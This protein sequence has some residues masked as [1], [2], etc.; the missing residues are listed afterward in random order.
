MNTNEIPLIN[1]PYPPDLTVEEVLSNRTNE[2]LRSRAPNKFFI[3]RLAY[4]KELKKRIGD[5]ISMIKIASH[6]SLSWS[7][8][9]S[10]IK[11]TYKKFSDRVENRL[12]EIRQND[13]LIIIHE[14]FLPSQPP[15]NNDIVDDPMFFYTYFYYLYY[16]YYYYS[17]YYSYYDCNN[18]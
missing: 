15:T 3:Y 13:N 14:N 1:V 4:I 5:N 9:P 18:Y 10:E 11:E 6:I 17:Y 12:K 8:E 16:Y 7:K 2:K